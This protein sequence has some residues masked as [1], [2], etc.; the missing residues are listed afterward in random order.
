MSKGRARRGG[1]AGG[2][3]ETWRR[4]GRLP[5]MLLLLRK[6]GGYTLLYT[7]RSC[8]V[9]GPF[10]F[11]RS[12]G[13]GP[14]YMRIGASVYAKASLACRWSCKGQGGGR[15]GGVDSI[16]RS[17]WFFSFLLLLLYCFVLFRR[18][19]LGSQDCFFLSFFVSSG[20]WGAV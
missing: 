9:V 10:F 12:V 16:V 13:G 5:S 6:G 17:C 2:G 18:G 4:S 11:G 19:F 3:L 8:V 1:G 7:I 14:L 20:G 15:G